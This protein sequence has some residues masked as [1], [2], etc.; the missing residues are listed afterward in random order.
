ML[1]NN[2][3]AL[4]EA[5]LTGIGV[6]NTSKKRSGSIPVTLYY[7]RRGETT[8]GKDLENGY[9]GAPLSVTEQYVCVGTGTTAPQE[10]DTRLENYLAAYSVK[11]LYTSTSAVSQDKLERKVN[12]TM[13]YTNDT[14]EDVTI[15]E[16]GLRFGVPTIYYA[17]AP[18]SIAESAL[19]GIT[20]LY[21][22]RDLLD[23]PVTVA[24]GETKAIVYTIDL[25]KL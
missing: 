3:K 13:S 6:A 7:D 14:E 5:A 20:H 25:S 1:L 2:G 17:K 4:I 22:T 21:I 9:I 23:T 10:T 16:I 24:P 18:N 8:S 15:S 19:S 12:Y 11:D